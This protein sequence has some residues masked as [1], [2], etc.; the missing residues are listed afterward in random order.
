MKNTSITY[1][2]DLAK[3]VGLIHDD[4]KAGITSTVW[5]SIVKVETPNID[6]EVHNKVMTE[7][8]EL[9]IILNIA[10]TRIKIIL[11]NLNLEMLMNPRS[12]GNIFEFEAFNVKLNVFVAY[13]D[14]NEIQGILIFGYDE[15][16]PSD[17]AFLKDMY[18]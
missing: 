1:V 12:F 3:Q 7:E 14:K 13:D 16:F 18:K 5:D 9:N 8:E 10:K 15:L 2:S 6:S 4:K 11:L 17:H